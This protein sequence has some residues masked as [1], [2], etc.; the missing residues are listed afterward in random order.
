MIILK[1][2]KFH[3]PTANRFSTAMKKPG[4]GHNDNSSLNR[5]NSLEFNKTSHKNYNATV[6]LNL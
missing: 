5:V 4:G 6:A 1:V 2:R 3:Q